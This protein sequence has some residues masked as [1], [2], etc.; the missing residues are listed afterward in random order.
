MAQIFD[1]AAKNILH[2]GAG[3]IDKLS[4][5]MKYWYHFAI[6]FEALFI[7]TTIDTGTRV[8]RFLLQESLGKWVHPRLGK[9]DWWPGV[10]L[11]TAA[12]V[13]GW[14]YFL[15]A[16]EMKAIW[17]MFGIANQMLAVI[18]LAVGTVALV[19][20]GKAKY[21]WVTVVPMCFVIL[22]TT[23]AGLML[24][25]RY[26]AVARSATGIDRLNALV[27]IACLSVIMACTAIVVVGGLLAARRPG[28][29]DEPA[30]DSGAQP[31][32]TA[33]LKA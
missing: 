17:P 3:T 19:H 27:T 26:V 6:M 21:A 12:M 13:A 10:L 8:G 25:T 33:E 23:T 22:T 4:G 24:L 15:E 30:A 28:P 32:A 5:M 18:A 29:V 7:L 2:A 31:P 14:W 16:K 20:M 9:T 11:T 1:T